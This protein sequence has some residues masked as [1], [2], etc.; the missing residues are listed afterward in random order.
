MNQG[1]NDNYL[2]VFLQEAGYNPYYTGKLFNAHDIGNYDSPFPAGWT[3]SDFLLDPYTYSY[4]NATY[5]RNQDPP[6]SYE[7]Q[8]TTDVL[9]GKALGF[10]DDAVHGG[11]PFFLGIA[12]VAPHSNVQH[13]VLD[14]IND[15]FPPE[16][17][18]MRSFFSAPIPAERHAHLFPDAVVPRTPNFNPDV[19]S[20]ANWIKQQSKQSPENVEYNDHFY[21]S[22][23]RAL[24]AVD[25]LVDS[26]INK[27]EKY[28]ILDDTYIFYTTDNGF[29]IGQHRLQP[30]KE[31]GFEEDIN[32]PLIIRGPGVPKGHVSEIVTT[33]TDLTPTIV[34]LARGPARAD[35][36]GLNIPLTEDG[37]NDAIAT[38]HEHVTVEFWGIAAGEGQFGYFDR[39]QSFILNNTYKAI[40]IVS[41]EYN[42]YYSVWCTNEH[43]LYDLN[44]SLTEQPIRSC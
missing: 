9:A 31:C 28:G 39:N 11:K 12:P 4:L 5:Q 33:H 24:Q 8:Y 29:H 23:L 19:A 44:V 7:G 25:E 41:K 35:F 27:L 34:D 13:N 3:G 21:R 17:V 36:D 10:L 38:R 32:I 43:E 22:R 42:L 30:G 14:R 26:V 20:G 6:V 40:R 15:T 1:L 37:L 2:P 16:D 18:D